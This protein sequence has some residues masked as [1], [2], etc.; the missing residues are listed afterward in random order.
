MIARRNLV[1]MLRTGGVK[2]PPDAVTLVD[3]FA[4]GL[5][6]KQRQHLRGQGYDTDCAC[7]G[8]SACLATEYIDLIDPEVSDG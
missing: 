2:H 1:Y 4:H 8:C 7:G 5:A 3:A 6:E